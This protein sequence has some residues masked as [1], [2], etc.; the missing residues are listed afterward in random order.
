MAQYVILSIYPMG[1]CSPGPLSGIE[2]AKMPF[3]PKENRQFQSNGMPIWCQWLTK[4]C[5]TGKSVSSSSFRDFLQSLTLL[6]FSTTAA[7]Y[8]DNKGLETHCVLSPRYVFL[9][10]I[11]YFADL[12]HHFNIYRQSDVY[13]HVCNRY[14]NRVLFCLS[15]FTNTTVYRT[16]TTR[17]KAQETDSNVSWAVSKFLQGF[18]SES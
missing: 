14:D 2:P 13:Q 3:L 10:I 9:F 11:R 16:C 4:S 6:S 7:K 1:S 17:I 8:N 12:L 15:Y 18:A 5:H